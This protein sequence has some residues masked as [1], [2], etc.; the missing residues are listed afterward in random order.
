MKYTSNQLKNIVLGESLS[1][2][3]EGECQYQVSKELLDELPKTKVYFLHEVSSFHTELRTSSLADILRNPQLLGSDVDKAFLLTEDGELMLSVRFF[4]FDAEEPED[5]T[6]NS[7]DSKR[8]RLTEEGKRELSSFLADQQ[9]EEQ[10]FR[11][12]IN[13]EAHEDVL[14]DYISNLHGPAGSELFLWVVRGMLYEQ[15]P[16]IQKRINLALQNNIPTE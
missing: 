14:Y 4:R 13:I 5:Y 9:Q 11:E 7:K 12:M 15:L 3:L 10:A 16:E 2:V 8:F 1:P 6:E